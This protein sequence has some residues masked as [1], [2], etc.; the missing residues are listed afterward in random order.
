MKIAI[1]TAGSGEQSALVV[2]QV[3]DALIVADGAV[4]V[5]VVRLRDYV[6]DLASALTALAPER[7]REVFEEVSVADAVVFHTSIMNASFAGLLKVFLDVLPEGTLRG[8]PILMVGTGGTQR[9]SLALDYALR[10][11]FT[12]LHAEPIPTTVFVAT[13]DWGSGG[14]GVRSVGERITAAAHELIAAARAQSLDSEGSVPGAGR[15]HGASPESQDDVAASA[16]ATPVA[17]PRARLEAASQMGSF[18]V[19]HITDRLK[20]L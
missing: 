1:V 7:L 19:A 9:H 10:P 15:S 5:N 3:A 17:R 4:N 14:D 2:Q 12:Y 13:S 6:Q 11:V 8:A 20:D 16:S 18:D